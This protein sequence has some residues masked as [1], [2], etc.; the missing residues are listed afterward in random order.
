MIDLE[1]T[2][3]FIAGFEGFVDHV[4]K[5]P[6][7]VDTIGYGET[8]PV[9]IAQ[10]RNTPMSKAEALDLLKRRVQGFADGVQ[11]AVSPA[12]MNQNQHEA[13][14]S[15][16]YNIGLGAFGTSTACQKFK[17]GDTMGAAHAITLWNKGGG[18]VLDGLVAR[19]AAEVKLFSGGGDVLLQL[20]GSGDA[21]AELQRLL[22]AAG[23]PCA[24]DG[25]FGSQ[26]A[27]AVT[28]FQA[29]RGLTADGVVGPE[30]WTALRRHPGPVTPWPGTQLNLGSNG[31][32]V[33]E[34]Q[35]R[36]LVLGFDL[37]PSGADG[38]FGAKTDQATRSFQGAH[39]LSRDGVVGSDTWTAAFNA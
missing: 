17:Q 21:V 36:L 23:F 9:V 26:T 33:A 16:A 10:H 1:F 39:G 19:R 14:T 25:Q 22:G 4:Y 2:A 30:T 7:G 32:H 34:L 35:R 11:A 3:T 31:P 28:A 24:A 12:A 38:D 5:D 27:S 8:D 13:F 6:G 15:L 37:G 18:K 29:S 20:N